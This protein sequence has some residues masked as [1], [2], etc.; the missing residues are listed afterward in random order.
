MSESH[1]RCSPAITRK[2]RV[3]ST[4]IFAV[5]SF[6]GLNIMEDVKRQ[7]TKETIERWVSAL[8]GI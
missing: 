2:V 3:C 1:R 8:Y 4:P 7:K 5:H 6:C